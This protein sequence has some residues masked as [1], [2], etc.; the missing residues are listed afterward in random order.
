MAKI[1]LT[2]GILA[3]VLMWPA[4][5]QAI[6]DIR[7]L[8][9]MIE[10]LNDVLG[11]GRSELS[12]EYVSPET[13]NRGRVEAIRP[14][15]E[16][17]GRPCWMFRRSYGGPGNVSTIEGRACSNTSLPSAKKRALPAP[18]TRVRP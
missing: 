3:G 10:T 1:R 9:P 14:A 4:A 5:G 17:N 7:D 2:V 6:E 16:S 8:G 13:G 15:G 11:I 12:M 18:G